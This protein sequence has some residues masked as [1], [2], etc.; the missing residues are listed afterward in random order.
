MT[1]AAAGSGRQRGR[2]RGNA[3]WCGRAC[4]AERG[5]A[6]GRA[7]RAGQGRR[8]SARQDGAR[9]GRARQSRARQGGARQTATHLIV[10]G[11]GRL[12]ADTSVTEFTAGHASLEDAFVDLTKDAVAYR[13]VTSE[14]EK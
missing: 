10:I 8:G 14:E 3:G 11:K 7:G 5:G 1:E 6:G 4:G 13:A 12:I 2:S 9:Q